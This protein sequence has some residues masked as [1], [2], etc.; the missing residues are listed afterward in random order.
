MLRNYIKTALRNLLRN[1]VYALINIF[2][3]SIGITCSLMIMIFIKHE[4]SYDKF[5]GKKDHLYRMVFELT[6]PDF[7]IAS[8]QM[9]A[10]VAPDLAE[11]FPEVNHV[12]R[13]TAYRQGFFTHQNKAYKAE[14]V[15]YA[16]SSFF[17]MFSYK[18]LLGNPET[19]LKEPYSLVLNEETAHHI[20]GDENPVGKVLRWNNKDDLVITGV[21]QSPLVNSHLQFTSLISFTSLYEDKRLYMDWNGGMQYYHYVELK[22]DI[23]KEEVEAKLPDFMYRHINYIYEQHNA[24]INASLQPVRDIH[25]KSGYAGEIGVVGSMSN[26]YIYSAI[27]LFILFIA[28]INFMNLTTA[29]STRRAKEVGMRKVLGAARNSLVGQFL[30]ES[31]MMSIIGFILAL[32]LIEIL[33][34]EFSNIVNRELELYQLKNLDLIIGVP[35]FIIIVGILAGSYPAFYISAFRPVTVMKGIFSGQKGGS[36]FRNILVLIQFAISLVLI[37]CTLV[38]YTQLNYIKSKDVGYQ[39]ENILALNFT[40]EDFKNKYEILKDQLKNIPGVISSSATSEVPGR[41]FTSNGYKP[42]GY[43][44]VLMFNAVDVDYD[45]F[46]TM[47]LQILKGRGFSPEFPTDKDAYLINE[48]LAKELN[49]E[50]PLEKTINRGGDHQ[51]I[52]VVNDFH[53]AS[54]HEEIAPLIFHMNPYLGYDFLLVRFKTDQLNS[55]INRIQLAWEKI[56]P[57]EPFEYFFLDDV[58]NEMYQAEKKMSSLLLYIA[59]LAIIIACMGLFGLAL[60]STEQRTKEIGVRKV[61]GSTVTRV[62]FHLTGNFTRWVLLAN[63]LAWPVAYLIVRKYMQIYA[64]RIN[65]PV[66]VFFL[67]ALLAYLIAL[68]TISFQSIKAGTRNPVEALRYE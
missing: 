39:K 52:G 22:P 43:D 45:Y 28:C 58:F 48:T 57:D 60:Y 38:I 26:I 62:V 20:F 55:L 7:E 42:E 61:L 41:G 17:E 1:P 44:Q 14:N 12:T 4:I 56:D 5:H 33:L 30:G 51:V 40:S 18:L 8:P 25:L 13:I 46:Q 3:L 6:S 21:V 63:I 47:G 66:W 65:L 15:L 2:G 16:D 11:E 34:P 49:W 10:P 24:S 29:K 23:T 67:T 36:G 50:N 68:F 37:I 53:F 35:V 19:V 64:Y 31:V 9:T 27:A 59:I 32:V 54:L